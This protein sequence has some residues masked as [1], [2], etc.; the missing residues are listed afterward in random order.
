MEIPIWLMII[1]TKEE[2]QIVPLFHECHWKSGD[3][4]KKVGTK[5]QEKEGGTVKFNWTGN[6]INMK[7]IISINTLSL[8]VK[9]VQTTG[10]IV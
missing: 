10:K 5:A 9:F 3:G 4:P 6:L 7:Y 1:S 8:F 2:A